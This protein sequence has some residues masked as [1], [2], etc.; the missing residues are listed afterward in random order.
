MITKRSRYAKCQLEKNGP[1]EYF[2]TRQI[3]VITQRPADR[4]HQVKDH[5]RIDALSFHYL[6]DPALWW[7]IADANDIAFPLELEAG[8]VLRI[9]SLDH[10]EMRILE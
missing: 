9:P 10:V 3:P 5:D 4:F 1:V 2:G 7:I 8:T 6:G